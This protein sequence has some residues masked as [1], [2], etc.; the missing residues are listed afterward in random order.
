MLKKLLV[1]TGATALTLGVTALPASAARPGDLDAHGN[2]VSLVSDNGFNEFGYNYTARIFSGPADG[3]DKVLDGTVWGD[4]T[5][6]NDLVVMKWNAEWDR[7]NA[8]GWS[9]PPYDTAWTTNEWN[10]KVPGGSGEVWHYKIVWVG[11]EL[12]SS[13]YWVPGGYGVWGQFEV[14]MDQG[15][16]PEGHAVYAHGIPNGLG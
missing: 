4:P 15:T 7:G 11:P 10:G 16:T 6:A 13:P 8:E 2:V 9:N 3:S 1:V 14:V 12:E 5:Y